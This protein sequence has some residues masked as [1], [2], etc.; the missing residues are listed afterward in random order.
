[1]KTGGEFVDDALRKAKRGVIV[2][3]F[4]AFP[5]HFYGGLRKAMHNFRIVNFCAEIKHRTSCV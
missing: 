3:Y 5:E 2:A 1:M 4:K